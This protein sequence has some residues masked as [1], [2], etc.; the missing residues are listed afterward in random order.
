MVHAAG[1]LA[2]VAVATRSLHPAGFLL[3]ALILLVGVSLFAGD[4]AARTFWGERLFPMAAPIG[5]ST[6][7][8]GWLVLSA[9]GLWEVIGQRG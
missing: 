3:A 2:I 1:A 5:G 6:M 8:V 9:A 4:I 7:I